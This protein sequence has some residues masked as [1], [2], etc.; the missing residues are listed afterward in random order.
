MLSKMICYS[1]MGVDVSLY[2]S[3]IIIYL[4]THDTLT[5]ILS[6]HKISILILFFARSQIF[7]LDDTMSN[8]AVPEIKQT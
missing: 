1:P 2:T 6:A 7:E 5:G 4:H 3:H 8:E